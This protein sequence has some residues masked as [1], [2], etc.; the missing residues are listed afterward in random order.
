MNFIV[1]HLLVATATAALKFKSQILL[2]IVQLFINVRLGIFYSK[3][4][5]RCQQQ[6]GNIGIPTYSFLQ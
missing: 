3:I 2:R 4:V 5:D 6:V 1:W